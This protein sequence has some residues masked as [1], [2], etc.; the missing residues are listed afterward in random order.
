[1]PA[2]SSA[3]NLPP[4]VQHL[5]AAVEDVPGVLSAQIKRVYLPD[6]APS[7][8][9]LPGEFADLPAA[10]LRRSRG[11]SPDESL[12]SV[13]FEIARS[14]SGLKG[15]EFLAW[16]VRDRARTGENIQ[17][18]ALALPPMANNTKQLG[19]TLRFTIDWFYDNPSQDM[20][21]LLQ[22]MD[23]AA[24]SIETFTGLYR[25]AF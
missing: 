9:S 17:L 5:K 14:E 21:V 20:A 3:Q 7:D 15:L 10:A 8:L 25:E 23:D 24:S 19:T 4:E 6:L 1:M 18:R 22:A 11:G 13:H 12:L 2:Q 16:W